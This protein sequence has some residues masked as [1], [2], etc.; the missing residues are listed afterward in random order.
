MVGLVE[1]LD[2]GGSACI[3]YFTAFYQSA[4]CRVRK[5]GNE[6]DVASVQSVSRV[7]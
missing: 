6:F 4:E 5:W 7:L 1:R 3:S 2:S